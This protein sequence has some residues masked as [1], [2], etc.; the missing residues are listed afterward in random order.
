MEIRKTSNASGPSTPARSETIKLLS[1]LI[2]EDTTNPPGNESRAAGVVKRFFETEGIA[3]RI[4][5]KEKG[6]ANIIGYIGKGHPRLLLACH[7]DVVPAGEGWDSNPFKARVDGDKIYGRGAV[8]NKGPLAGILMAAKTLKKVESSLHGQVIV[9][10]VADEEAG[11]KAGMRYLLDECGLSAEYAIV[12]DIEHEL[13]K[14]DVAEKGLLFLKV[15]SFGKQAHGSAPDEGINAVWHM[16][17][18]LKLLKGYD[19]RMKFKKH[20]LLSPPTLNLGIVRG[21][22][23][24]NIVPAK[25]EATIDIRYLPSQSSLAIIGDVKRMLAAVAKKNKK[26]RFTLEVIDDQKPVAVDGG[27]ALIGMIKK[28]V[29]EVTGKKAEIIGI[30][31]TTLIKPLAAAGVTAVGFSPGKGLAHMSNEYISLAELVHF[32]ETIVLVCMD[33]LA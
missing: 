21:G 6:R 11:S 3:Y 29:V 18:F 7:M 19:K 4:F 2:A 17:E 27:N 16:V 1:D 8:D 15:T 22:E 23:A 5:E 25:C 26:A 9:A 10:C 20:A 28:R 14:I 33:L 31:G 12:P 30:S 32:S 24:A 13:R